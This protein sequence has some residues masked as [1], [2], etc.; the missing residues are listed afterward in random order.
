M[1][2]HPVIKKMSLSG[3]SGSSEK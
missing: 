3:P 2:L 1:Y